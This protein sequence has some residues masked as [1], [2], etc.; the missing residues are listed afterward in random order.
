[1][2]IIDMLDRQQQIEPLGS[3]TMSHQGY[4]DKWGCTSTANDESQFSGGK[5]DKCVLEEVK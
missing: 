3:Y 4:N 1:M 2:P 5:D